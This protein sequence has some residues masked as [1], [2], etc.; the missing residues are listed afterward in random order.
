MWNFKSHL[1]A[2]SSGDRY[3][4]TRTI[5]SS[6]SSSQEN[7][8]SNYIAKQ[9]T[10]KLDLNRLMDS[11]KTNVGFISHESRQPQP[12]PRQTKTKKTGKH[13]ETRCKCPHL[14]ILKTA[15]PSSCWR[16][17]LGKSEAWWW[18]HGCIHTFFWICVYVY[19][20]IIKYTLYVLIFYYDILQMHTSWKYIDEPEAG[21]FLWTFLGDLEI[22]KSLHNGTRIIIPPSFNCEAIPSGFLRSRR[23]ELW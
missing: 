21:H 8:G 2:A 20:K 10:N 13:V 12:S 1:S 3:R 5:C 11:D 14:R 6:R 15:L 17:D 7:V 23:Q 22:Q 9:E 4:T 16:T 19:V 18:C